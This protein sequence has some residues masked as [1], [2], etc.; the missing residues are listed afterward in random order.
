MLP[1]YIRTVHPQ[2]RETMKNPTIVR[3]SFTALVCVML[4]MAVFG[5]C[6]HWLFTI[7]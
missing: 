1:L 4:L 6:A 3:V 7:L 2:I 5:W